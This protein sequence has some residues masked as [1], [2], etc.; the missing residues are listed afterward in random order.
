ML[1]GAYYI[2]IM[3]TFFVG[4]W[5]ILL[6][7][8]GVLWVGHWMDRRETGAKHGFLELPEELREGG[9]AATP[10][11]TRSTEDAKDRDGTQ[12]G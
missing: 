3:L 10:D 9:T 4:C 12:R 5:A 2:W 1:G 6:L 7:I 11:V 8:G